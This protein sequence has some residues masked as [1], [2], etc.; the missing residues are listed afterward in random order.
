MAPSDFCIFL[1]LKGHLRGHHSEVKITM[2][3]WSHQQ[4]AHFYPDGLTKLR[5]H[6][7]KYVHHSNDY[8]ITE[9]NQEALLSSKPS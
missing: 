6:W 7:W 1:K 3:M 9:K 4:D 5:E 2:K 8:V